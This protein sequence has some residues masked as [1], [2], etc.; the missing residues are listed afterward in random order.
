MLALTLFNTSRQAVDLFYRGEH[1]GTLETGLV[2]GCPV[3]DFCEMRIRV[4]Y[5]WSG[6]MSRHCFLFSDGDG[7]HIGICKVEFN[8]QRTKVYIDA[9]LDLYVVRRNAQVREVREGGDT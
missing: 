1:C 8:G 9:D 4:G 3:V 5:V 7:R 2:S 6:A